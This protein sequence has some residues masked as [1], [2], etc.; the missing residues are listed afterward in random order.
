MSDGPHRCLPMH[1]NW[2]RVAKCADMDAFSC[3]DIA[4][5]V[6]PAL[7]QDWKDVPKNLITALKKCFGND[8][9]HS[10]LTR[11]SDIEALRPF[12]AGP[13]LSGL[14]IDYAVQAIK[15][16]QCGLN[17]LQSIFENA[18]S[19]WAYS[20]G[21]QI[22]EHFYRKSDGKRALNVRTRIENGIGQSGISDFVSRILGGSYSRNTSK[23]VKKD[24]LDDGPA[25]L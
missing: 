1:K 14:I 7:S 16:T 6:I 11:A 8:E 19:E 2:Q 13:S 23:I 10:L 15:R 5:A 9:Q 24:G 21:R 20:R 18:T 22:E 12:N 3:V 17:V 25:I 4:T